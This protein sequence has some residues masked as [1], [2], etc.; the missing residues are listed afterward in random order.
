MMFGDAG[1]IVDARAAQRIDAELEAGAADGV[2]VDDVAQIGDIGSTK[3]WR[4]VVA[5][6]KRL[7]VGDALDA[8]RRLASRSLARASMVLV[9]S[10][11]GGSA[12]RRIVFESAVFGRVVRG[13]DHDAV[14]EA[15]A[16]RWPRL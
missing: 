3:L 9:A 10:V 7:R 8:V 13:R 14:G 5:A 4:C 15:G 1:P 6:A 2:H 12:V 11:A 16:V